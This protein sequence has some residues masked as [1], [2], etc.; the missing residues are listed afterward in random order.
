[1]DIE[2]AIVTTMALIFGIAGLATAMQSA[3][4]RKISAA[5][6]DSTWQD[7]FKVAYTTL[8]ATC[9]QPTC[10][11]CAFKRWNDEIITKAEGK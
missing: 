11:S 5:A 1:M 10:D 4:T 3:A 9:D 2:T 6:D 7:R 8:C